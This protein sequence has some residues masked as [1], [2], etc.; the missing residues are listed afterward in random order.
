V[1]RKTFVLSVLACASAVHCH[2]GD[3]LHAQDAGTPAPTP[4]PASAPSA[5]TQNHFA[6]VI[7]DIKRPL[8]G[9]DASPPLATSNAS[10]VVHAFKEKLG[11]NAIRLYIDP[12]IVDSAAYPALYLQ[13]LHIARDELGMKVYAN[14]LA[15]GR[16]GKSNAD[17]AHW[18]AGYA[19]AF[20][21]DFLGPFN[22]S[23]LGAHELLEIAVSVRSALTTKPLL[24][25]PD[26]QK[27]A[28]TQSLFTEEPKLA[29]AFD[30]DSSHDA[31]DDEGA[32]TAAWNQLAATAARTTWATEDPRSWSATSHA[33]EE[34]GVRA[35]AQS[36]VAG[37]VLYEAFPKCV[38]VDGTLTEKGKEIARGLRR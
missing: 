23:G 19:N 10:T 32:T 15:T 12:S 26:A 20:H 24:V 14:P 37:V 38:S 22:E 36:S 30:I 9:S 16:F 4:A 1:T 7:C 34:V 21:P 29:A 8:A 25:G 17:Y 18:I 6:F 33:G 13:V 3:T 11:C 2:A 27:V 5:S 28:K 35:V 31:V